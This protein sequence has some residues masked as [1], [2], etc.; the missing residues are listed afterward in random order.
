MTG[1]DELLTPKT[2]Y[3]EKVFDM[4]HKQFELERD[5]LS[6]KEE[7]D[8]NAPLAESRIVSTAA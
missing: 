7:H 5:K 2:V 6:R 4:V 8:P 1:E 3:Q